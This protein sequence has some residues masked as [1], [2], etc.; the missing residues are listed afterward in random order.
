[1]RSITPYVARVAPDNKPVNTFSS[2]PFL[3][4]QRKW[5]FKW[6]H[7]HNLMTRFHF[8]LDTR[9]EIQ[10]I[11][12]ALLNR[13]QGW[14]ESATRKCSLIRFIPWKVLRVLNSSSRTGCDIVSSFL[15]LVVGL[16]LWSSRK[17]VAR[18]NTCYVRTTSQL[19]GNVLIF[20]WISMTKPMPVFLGEKY[21]VITVTPVLCKWQRCINLC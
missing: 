6:E 20:C 2:R 5:S 9:A 21:T 12:T 10:F 8:K 13:N 3:L 14:T 19:I 15:F 16:S 11:S 18:S 1:M 7:V 4:L 17:H